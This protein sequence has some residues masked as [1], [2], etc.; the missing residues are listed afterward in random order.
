MPTLG[1][2]E[3]IEELGRGGTSVV[4][5]ARD[6]ATERE[7]AVKVLSSHL[8][9]D[10][11]LLARFEREIKLAVKLE[12]PHIVP[13]LDVGTE[14]DHPY[15]VM[16]LL[17]GG[18]LA[19]RLRRGPLSAADTVRILMEVASAL[20]EAHRLQIV[21]RDLKPSNILFDRHGTAYLADF[22]VARF[23]DGGESLT[24][25][26]GV[27]GTPA[28]MSPEQLKGVA[29]TGLADQYALGLVAFQALTGRLPFEGSTAQMI[30][31]QLQEPLPSVRRYNAGLSPT[32]E[33]VLARATA[34][35]PNARYATASEFAA[36]LATAV[37]EA[38]LPDVA[39]RPT[40]I[41]E[42]DIA[43]MTPLPV[44]VGSK[45]APEAAQLA[46][47]AA[48]ETLEEPGPSV[49]DALVAVPGMAGTERNSLPVVSG[50]RRRPAP[51]RRP[52]V[53]G[54]VV[55]ALVA[56]MGL[57]WQWLGATG[58]VR[59]TPVSTATA[60]AASTATTAGPTEAASLLI[61]LA[62]DAL[63]L[64]IV[65]LPPGAASAAVYDLPQGA[66][67]VTVPDQSIVQ[68][69]RGRE[70]TPD[71]TLWTK[72]RLLS[73]QEGWMADGLLRYLSTTVVEATLPATVGPSNNSTAT[74]AAGA[75]LT[76]T[77]PAAPGTVA[78]TAALPGG[79]TG[80]PS[81][82][83]SAPTNT[84]RPPASSTAPAPTVT[85]AP[86]TPTPTPAPPTHT[87]IPPTSTSALCD[88]LGT[89]VPCP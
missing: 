12:H 22:G 21:H 32:F 84:P 1:R 71:G 75:T 85:T 6:Q 66:V 41:T 48:P 79:I 72:V 78:P 39:P 54:L 49:A 23:M 69:L 19:D 63:A 51:R 42:Q 8:L 5:R 34:K 87:P 88:L 43:L 56:L 53:F 70:T 65:S 76:R 35:N 38:P 4:Y 28:Y 64:A 26:A 13:I 11:D 81:A 50:T 68:V 82:T 45:R 20:D 27:V 9:H 86:S 30:L 80:S 55:I 10:P 24:A 46:A 44:L 77:P 17:S 33:R 18:S 74:R 15:I 89:V 7:V 37:A 60:P 47:L 2:Y 73:G 25:S 40:L 57:G 52:L 67:V 61:T 3:T 58:L 14:G 29:V 31:Q 83:N 36:A 62:P 16:R 59:M